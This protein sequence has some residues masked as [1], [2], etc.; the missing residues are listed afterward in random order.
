MRVPRPIYDA[1][2]THARFCYPEEAC[3]LIAGDDAGGLEMAYC[4]TNAERSSTSYTIDPEEHFRALRHAE[5]QGWD[6]VA[7]FH[8]HPRSPAYPSATDRSLA[9]EPEWVYLIVSLANPEEPVVRGYRLCDEGVAE[10]QI[11]IGA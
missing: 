9:A 10:V 4:L 11:E 3:G 7:T 1:M 2:V 6:L 5:R 8:S